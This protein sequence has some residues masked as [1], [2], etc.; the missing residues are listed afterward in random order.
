MKKLKVKITEQCTYKESKD[1]KRTTRYDNFIEKIPDEIRSTYFP[2]LR[3]G[4]ENI[5][6][7]RNM[8]RLIVEDYE[9]D[10]RVPRLTTKSYIK[11]GYDL[12]L[13]MVYLSFEYYEV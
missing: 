7:Y 11:E 9:K 2:K 8:K 13:E 12:E 10:G 1:N 4:H 3:S 6:N 5:Y